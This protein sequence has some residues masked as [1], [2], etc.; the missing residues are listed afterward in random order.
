M[1]VNEKILDKILVTWIKTKKNNMTKWTKPQEC[2]VGFISESQSMELNTLIKEKNHDHF[3]GSW[4]F[5]KNA[6][7]K[8]IQQNRKRRNPF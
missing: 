7:N 5:H 2:Q 8:N 6:L 1:N 3:N 4:E